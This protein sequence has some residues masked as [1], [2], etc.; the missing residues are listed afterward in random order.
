MARSCSSTPLGAF[1]ALML[2]V[3]TLIPCPAISQTANDGFAAGSINDTDAVVAQPD[4]KIIVGGTFSDV[5]GVPRTNLAR[6]TA[7]GTLDASFVP[8]S[9]DGTVRTIAL[10][11]DGKVLIGGNFTH[12]GGETRSRIARLNPN[13]S[14]DTGFADV[15][16]DGAVAATLLLADGRIVV[17]GSFQQAGLFVRRGIARLNPDGGVDPGFDAEVSGVL[18]LAAQ[19]DG[20]I[21]VGGTI[22]F[23]NGQFTQRIAR[24]TSSGQLDLAFAAGAITGGTT[25]VSTLLVQPDGKL[26]LGGDFNFVLGQPR[27]HLAR[28]NTDGSLD[29]SFSAFL[30]SPV[31]DAHLTDDSR[32][33]VLTADGA[34]RRV[35]ASGALDQTFADCTCTPDPSSMARQP[36]GKIVTAGPGTIRRYD[37]D[38][39]P[40]NAL[41]AATNNFVYSAVPWVAS[42]VAIG[43]TFSEV[44]SQTRNRFARINATGLSSIDLNADGDVGAF[45][46]EPDGDLVVGGAFSMIGGAARN[47]LARFEPT[48][49]TIDTG[50]NPNVAGPVHSI[51]RQ[52]D[53]KLVI[54]GE[55]GSVAGAPNTEFL[56]RLRPDGTLDP[57]FDVGS[58]PNNRVFSVALEPD[59]SLLLAGEFSQINGVPRP[60]IARLSSA[61]TLDLAFNPAL[62][63]QPMVLLRQPDGRILVGGFVS[64]AGHSGLLRLHPDGTVDG[65]FDADFNVE[66]FQIPISLALQTDGR[67]VVGG[68]FASIGGVTGVSGIARLHSDGSVDDSF[69]TGANGYVQ[70]V[71]L[72]RDGKTLLGGLF[73]NVGGVPRSHLARLSATAPPTHALQVT[74]FAAGGTEVL[75]LR[76]GTGPELTLP[77]EL[78][79]S[80]GG[81]T[82]AT[83]GTMQPVAGGWRFRGEN[84]VAPLG[85]SFYLRA[86]GTG[87]A[88][89]FNGSTS[90]V[91]IVRQFE[92]DAAAVT[93]D[94][95]FEDG[96]E[97][98][99]S[100][101]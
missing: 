75:W 98:L 77:P 26:L 33:V 8:P 79:F 87:T 34:L 12:V 68:N 49:G 57:G 14:L 71:A 65:T 69:D 31:R 20:R 92:F 13:G 46:V 67:V 35:L 5:S 21:W 52:A 99:A 38:G 15:A 28:L 16:L 32:T 63:G 11:P 24:L 76:G 30:T 23:V 97:A 10:Q 93:G 80:I 48:S 53:G 94:D 39:W 17:A 54:G 90:L 44:A 36:D 40:D 29:G 61:G 18:S 55:F 1:A 86:Q 27:N 60:G 88:G 41:T 19:A 73:S 45:L 85:Q 9:I 50:F 43:G 6:L 22:V 58:G 3:G 59:G 82:F 96:F 25:V 37:E 7:D 81:V 66:N 100:R 42:S 101:G 89:R 4:G 91:E 56:A 95:I 70:S 2:A 78:Q 83:V 47:G 84:F 64:A 51:V 72:Q 74:P 62:A